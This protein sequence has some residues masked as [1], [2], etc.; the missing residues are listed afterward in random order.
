MQK[1]L[2]VSFINFEY[3]I[4]HVKRRS[5]HDRIIREKSIK[6]VSNNTMAIPKVYAK[7]LILINLLIL[8][9]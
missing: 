2:L 6:I 7:L 8:V 4:W 9:Y 5:N 3:Y 1:I